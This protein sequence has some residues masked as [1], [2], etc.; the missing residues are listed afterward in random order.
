M[1]AILTRT[2]VGQVD[3]L[4]ADRRKFWRVDNPPQDDILPHYETRP[5]KRIIETVAENVTNRRHAAG[6]RPGSRRSI[7]V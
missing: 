6:Y 4:R 1:L 3:N 2:E 5:R 7:P